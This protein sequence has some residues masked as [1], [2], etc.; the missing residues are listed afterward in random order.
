MPSKLEAFGQVGLESLACKTPVLSF[1]NTGPEDM[2]EH[3]KNGYLS[4][5]LDKEDFSNGIKWYLNLPHL[6]K[7]KIN[8]YCREFVLKK[9]DEK[10]ILNKYLK[11]YN[12]LN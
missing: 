11:I 1:R 9:F 2:I 7:Q 3:K 10:I 6:D 8:D 4:N 5:Y 12:K